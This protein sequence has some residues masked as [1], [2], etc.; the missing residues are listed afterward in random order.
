MAYSPVQQYKEQA[1]RSMTSGELLVLLLDEAIKNLKVSLMLLENRDEENYINC[2][3]KSKDIFFYL[4]NICDS[5][6]E[7]SSDLQSMYEF[8][9]TEL[10]SAEIS[11]DKKYVEDILPLVT[12]LRDT[13]IEANRITSKTNS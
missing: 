8:F 10:M 9:N 4:R 6:Y 2:L 1:I 11:K 3:K 7:I 13:W 5:K 12:D